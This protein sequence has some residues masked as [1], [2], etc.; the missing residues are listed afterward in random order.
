MIDAL[1]RSRRRLDYA[2]LGYVLM[3]EHAHL[4]VLPRSPEASV[5]AILQSIKQPVGV[6][7]LRARPSKDDASSSRRVFW[8]RGGG[9]DRNLTTA[10]S[11]RETLG[12]IH[13][14]PVRRAL[15]AHPEDWPWSSARHYAARPDALLP[16][17][18]PPRRPHPP[19]QR[20]DA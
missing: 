17:D 8:Q 2:L 18:A 1:D 6:R 5:A 10:A 19:D 7:A 20:T 4:I 13:A 12:Y 16:M 9:F 11:V 15:V 3:P 14:N